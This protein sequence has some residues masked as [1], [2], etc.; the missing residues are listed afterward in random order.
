MKFKVVCGDSKLF[1]LKETLKYLKKK[2]PESAI[3]VQQVLLKTAGY[4]SKN[5]QVDALDRF[6]VDTDRSCRRFEQYSYRVTY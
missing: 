3:K 1:Q 4:L 2:L 6:R 5:V